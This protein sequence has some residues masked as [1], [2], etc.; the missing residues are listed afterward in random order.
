MV[1]LLVGVTV[2][3]AVFA[4]AASLGVS[5]GAI[6][7]GSDT[8]LRCDTDGVQV[9]GWGLETDDGKV[10][11]VR[12]GGVDTACVGDDLFVVVT[13]EG[14]ALADGKATIAS[15]SATIT[16][17]E[18]GSSNTTPKPVKAEDITD[19]EVFIEGPNGA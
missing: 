11:N 9:L 3:G 2:F 18:L 8:E 17:T 6:Q 10:Y 15:A 7:A 1:A 4:L 16:L 19:I 12:I 13:H 5:G 14:T